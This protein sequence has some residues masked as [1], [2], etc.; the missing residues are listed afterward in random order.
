MGCKVGETY[1]ML[2]E[3]LYCLVDRNPKHT[4]L[5]VE[6]FEGLIL[7]PPVNL[8]DETW[9]DQ[10]GDCLKIGEQSG[11]GHIRFIFDYTN[12]EHIEKALEVAQN[13]Q[14]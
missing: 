13:F 14:R 7:K 6:K 10:Q 3:N 2:N 9:E 5:T 11:K 8:K 4:I 1:T 12:I